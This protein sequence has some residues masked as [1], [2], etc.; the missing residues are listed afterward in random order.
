MFV[1]ASFASGGQPAVAFD[2]SEH[3]YG[4]IPAKGGTAQHDFVV[5]NTGDT[6]LL[7]LKTYTSCNCTSLAFP[8]KPVMPGDSAILRVT[9]D[10]KSQEGTFFKSIQIYTND[11]AAKRSII[12]IKGE[13]VK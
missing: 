8:K 6:P 7:I 11:P 10:P 9:Y 12:T 4:S 5:R 1:L 3:D 13:V 2:S